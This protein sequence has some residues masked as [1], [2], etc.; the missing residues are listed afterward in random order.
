MSRLTLKIVCSG[1][2]K[3]RARGIAADQHRSVL[4]EAD[5]AGHEGDAVLV[6]NDDDAAVLDVRREAERGAQI[7]ADDGRGHNE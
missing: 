7:D 2:L 5:H 6:A 1:S 4:M 3:A